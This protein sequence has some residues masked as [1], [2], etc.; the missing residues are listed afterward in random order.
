[1]TLQQFII[2]TEEQLKKAPNLFWAKKLDRFAHIPDD[3]STQTGGGV[4][5]GKYG[6]LLGNNYAADH[7]KVCKEC[8]KKVYEREVAKTSS[9]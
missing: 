2:K 9:L 6:A 3:K 8:V 7:V 5:C 4:M 1:M